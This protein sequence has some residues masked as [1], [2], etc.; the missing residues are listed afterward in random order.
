M[1]DATALEERTSAVLGQVLALWTVAHEDLDAVDHQ[2]DAHFAGDLD[3][4]EEAAV[5]LLSSWRRCIKRWCQSPG[6]S[7]EGMWACAAAAPAANDADEGAMVAT[8]AG[9]QLP[10]HRALLV[11]LYKCMLITSGTRYCSHT[12]EIP[13]ILF[14]RATLQVSTSTHS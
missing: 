7:A 4:D 8:A 14:W 9:A 12:N 11:V 1:S 2:H 3:L 13:K 6:G 5:G 10:P